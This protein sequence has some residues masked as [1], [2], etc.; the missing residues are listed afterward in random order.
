MEKLLDY[1]ICKD[2]TVDE[3]IATIKHIL[4]KCSIELNEAI[5]ERKGNPV[6]SVRLTIN[7]TNIGTNGKGTNLKNALASGYAEF[8]ERLQNQILEF[9]FIDDTYTVENGLEYLKN[10]I[11]SKSELD[12]PTSYL[13]L[14][15]AINECK[16]YYNRPQKIALQKFYSVKMH[17]EVDLPSDFIHFAQGSNGMAAGNTFEEAIV[18]GL[19]EICERYTTKVI[20]T[21]HKNI[22]TIPPKYYEK[23]ENIKSLIQYIESN[24]YKITIKDASIGKFP[25]IITIF[26]DLKYK[27]NGVTIRPGSH[28]YFPVA[29]ERTLT[30]F[31]QGFDI[32]NEDE[33]KSRKIFKFAD[34]DILENIIQD[35]GRQSTP[36]DKTNPNFVNLFSDNFDYD[37]NPDI[38]YFKETTNQEMLQSLCKS[39]LADKDD[40]FIRNYDFLGFPVVY[41]YIP[42]MSQFYSVSDKTLDGLLNIHQIR[43]N[44]KE[45]NYSPLTVNKIFKACDFNSSYKFPVEPNKIS[46][47]TPTSIALCCAILMDDFFNIK[48]YINRIL[49]EIEIDPIY[50]NIQKVF[51]KILASYFNLKEK[52]YDKNT[53]K[54]KL[55]E[56]YDKQTVNKVFVFL[57][58]L[59]FERIIKM[60]EKNNRKN[61]KPDFT[62]LESKLKELYLK[63]PPSQTVFKQIFNKLDT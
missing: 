58:A 23:Y 14:Q 8:I 12:S 61:K 25:V 18:Q 44:L 53:I 3:T 17:K 33:R 56:Q 55:L 24:G 9:Y 22:P 29:V 42:K 28:P 19:S 39:I 50:Q 54:T 20:L 45:N 27:E 13:T 41:I 2:K 4:H 32:E 34:D 15:S 38:W 51:Y 7:G 46:D 30:E 5:L 49:S 63:N 21:E 37:F 60:L 35:I 43:N 48:K 57:Q 6:A 26:E 36:S 40:I 47:I 16:K 10:S 11:V 1:S 59:N 52:G 62:Y 31:L